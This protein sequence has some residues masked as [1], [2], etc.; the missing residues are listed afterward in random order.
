MDVKSFESVSDFLICTEDLLLQNESFYNLKLGLSGAIKNKN[1]EVENPLFF[2]V[3]DNEEL[4]GCALRTHADK[5]IAL[6]KMSKFAILKLVKTLIEQKITLAGVIG[7]IE[8]TN[9]FID[10]NS[11]FGCRGRVPDKSTAKRRFHA[12]HVAPRS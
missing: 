12:F 7:E 3:F 6:S 10:R 1:I 9:E 2:A 5:P 8:T 4:V 11:L